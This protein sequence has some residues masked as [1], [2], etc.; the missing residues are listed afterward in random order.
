MNITTMHRD[1]KIEYILLQNK[2]VFDLDGVNYELLSLADCHATIQK[3]ESEGKKIKRFP[4]T[5][6][7]YGRFGEVE[8]TSIAARDRWVVATHVNFV[9]KTGRGKAPIDKFVFDSPNNQA[10]QKLVTG[11]RLHIKILQKEIEDL[12]G[13]MDRVT[14]D[15]LRDNK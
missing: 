11:N 2:W 14:L 6:L 15:I 5:Y 1:I 13:K 3:A 4:C 8:I 7:D 9:S 10:I 12:I